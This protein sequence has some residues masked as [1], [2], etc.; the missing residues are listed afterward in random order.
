MSHKMNHNYD[1][2]KTSTIYDLIDFDK[3]DDTFPDDI[4]LSELEKYLDD[5]TT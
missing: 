3:L 1:E 2:W 5:Q 4:D